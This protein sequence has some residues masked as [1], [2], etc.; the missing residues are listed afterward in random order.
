LRLILVDIRGHGRSGKPE[1]CYTRLDFAYDIKLLLDAW[2]C[3][4]RDVVGHSSAASLR[5]PSP[6]TGRNARDA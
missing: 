3:S 1:C 2:A 4:V 6:S 5:R